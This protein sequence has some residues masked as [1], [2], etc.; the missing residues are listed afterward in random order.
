MICRDGRKIVGD[1][2]LDSFRSGYGRGIDSFKRVYLFEFGELNVDPDKLRDSFRE[3]LR[4][5]ERRRKE[6]AS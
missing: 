3:M 4:E 1:F 5:E 6:R 2:V